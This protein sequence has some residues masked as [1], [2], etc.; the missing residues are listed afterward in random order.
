M[1]NCVDISAYQGTNIDFAKMKASGIKCVIIKAGEGQQI[2]SSFKPQITA[3]I[4]AGMPVGIYWFS[5]AYTTDMAKAEANKCAEAIKPYKIS[6][7]VFI[8]FEYDSVYTMQAAGV[9]PTMELITNIHYVFCKTIQDKGYIGGY[10][11]NPDFLSRY[12]NASKLTAFYKWI[13]CWGPYP[14]TNCD[15]WQSGI[16]R[17]A[18]LNCD[19]DLDQIISQRLAN[20]VENATKKE[21]PKKAE[22][23]NEQIAVEVIQGRWGLGIARRNALTAAGYD[24]SA[25]Q[26]LVDSILLGK[27]KMPAAGSTQNTSPTNST[28]KPSEPASSK[29]KSITEVA[30]EV[31][32]GKW[33]AGAERKKKLTDAGYDYAAVQNKVDELMKKNK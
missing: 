26:G 5:R 10:Y 16:G 30:K 13:A 3:A 22:K 32:I 12:V 20:L 7:P 11:T 23:T 19:V 21:A 8:D 6:L 28:T 29:K 33:G 2:Y 4:D 27:T 15:L 25:I 9:T 31:I 1:T 18:G 14:Y 24:Y 17:V